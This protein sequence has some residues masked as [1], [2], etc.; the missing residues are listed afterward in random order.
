MKRNVHDKQRD[1]ESE[2]AVAESFH[3]VL[4]ENPASAPGVC[5]SLH[6]LSPSHLLAGGVN[7][8]IKA[9]CGSPSVPQLFTV[10]HQMNAV[11]VT[12]MSAGLADSQ[13]FRELRWVAWGV[14]QRAVFR[15]LPCRS[16][17][18][19]W[20]GQQ[21]LRDRWRWLRIFSPHPR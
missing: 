14:G 16:P 2:H 5:V 4:A 11:T 8:L 18:S 6:G 12:F 21:H 10:A 13:I 20:P 17:R 19:A 3:P 7:L 9:V 15:L 1:G